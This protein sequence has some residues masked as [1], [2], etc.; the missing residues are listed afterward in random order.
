MKVY[1]LEWC[2]MYE[3]PTLVGI[4][5]SEQQAKIVSEE[6]PPPDTHWWYEIHEITVG[7][8]QPDFVEEYQALIRARE[9]LDDDSY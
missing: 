1:L 4:F 6:A 7:K 8:I 9:E 5:F 2:Q 3:I